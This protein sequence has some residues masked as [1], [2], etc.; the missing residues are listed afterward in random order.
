MK[1]DSLIASV[2]TNHDYQIKAFSYLYDQA[3]SA[4]YNG[5]GILVNH[6]CSITLNKI[7]DLI[8]H[9][10]LFL[11]LSE[12]YWAPILAL[13]WLIDEYMLFPIIEIKDK[14]KTE[15]DN[16]VSLLSI[17]KNIIFLVEHNTNDPKD[18]IDN[19]F[20]C[21]LLL[22]INKSV[23]YVILLNLAIEIVWWHNPEGEDWI[24]LVD[25]WIEK[26]G[27]NYKNDLT[28]LKNR[29]MMQTEILF[30]TASSTK[31]ELIKKAD[32]HIQK[33]CHIWESF[34]DC[35]YE[36]LDI[37]LKDLVGSMSY[38]SPLALPIFH[39]HHLTRFHRFSPG[40]Q[41]IGLTRRRLQIASR[42]SALFNEIRD[43]AFY[44]KIA[45][46]WTK[47]MPFN[48]ATERFHCFRLSMLNQIS[49]LRSWE[50]S[51][52][53]DGIKQQYEAN[54]ELFRFKNQEFIPHVASEMIRL[55]AISGSF[56]KEDSFL[57]EAVQKMD[58]VPE[59]Y[60]FI[61]IDT[62]LN[63]RRFSWPS[64]R[65]AFLFLSDSIP[66]ELL[67]SV[68]NWCVNYVKNPI[69]PFP[70]TPAELLSIWRDILG[71]TIRTE[72]LC[73]ILHPLALACAGSIRSWMDDENGILEYIVNAPLNLAIEVGKTMFTIETDDINF[74]PHR[75][76]II[77]SAT[78]K[79][80]EL[81]EVF[82]DFLVTT[83]KEPIQ[84][85]HLLTLT[86]I[87]KKFQARDDIELRNWCRNKILSKC[88]SVIERSPKGFSFG[89]EMSFRVIE[90]VTWP[91]EEIEIINSLLEA[92]NAP[93]VR[94]YEISLFLNYLA[95]LVIKGPLSQL[96]II[97]DK[98]F[99]WLREMPI[100]ENE[101]VRNPLSTFQL[102]MGD[103]DDIFCALCNLCISMCLKDEMNTADQV[104]KWVIRNV[105]IAPLRSMALMFYLTSLLGIYYNY[106]SE[107][108]A[109]ST[110][111]IIIMRADQNQHNKPGD[112]RH[113]KSLIHQIEMLFDSSSETPANLSNVKNNERLCLFF[114][115]ISFW[116]PKLAEYNNP[117]IRANTARIICFWKQLST[118][119]PNFEQILEK[120]R[121]DARA[122]VRQAACHAAT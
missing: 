111:H 25:A 64:I 62:L 17:L 93:H 112:Y 68:A 51:S 50:L 79:R 11:S 5:D 19:L 105:T 9:G 97:R 109:I 63:M 47:E 20:N 81:T 31:G 22:P 117:A 78:I 10:K 104:A 39:L 42:K 49:A 46:L 45:D 2:G 4:H 32:I 70:Q 76:S 115:A 121:K 28:K 33:I 3:I 15:N 83:A 84:K 55:A 103:Y 95:E 54:R 23:E 77:F 60:R 40:S 27:D 107:I 91:D 56:Q 37:A 94:D 82:K 21:D 61:L 98:F 89:G 35:N 69:P 118:L 86:S 66:E 13:Y 6:L 59:G 102:N 110:L 24:N 38:E 114:R 101:T 106:I 67:P 85:F 44:R 1:K 57:I 52:L 18:A 41:I 71:Y 58:E 43:N 87:E 16:E 108:D 7:S 90:L 119:P 65:N 120:L 96:A 92:I 99:L 48:K 72:E 75:W 29:L 73:W 100:G 36:T 26:G 122:R 53:I 74:N 80:P 12:F 113:I 30:A 88:R 14:I 8:K 116:I 34:M